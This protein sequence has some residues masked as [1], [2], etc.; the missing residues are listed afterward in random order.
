MNTTSE[1][2]YSLQDSIPEGYEVRLIFDFDGWETQVVRK[3]DRKQLWEETGIEAR[4]DLVASIVRAIGF[5]RHE[6][7]EGD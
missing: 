4:N 2:I 7:Y 6:A 5:A 3:I 1:G